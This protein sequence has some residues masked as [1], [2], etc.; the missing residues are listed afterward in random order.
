M[1][2]K[3]FLHNIE[4]ETFARELKCQGRKASVRTVVIPATNEEGTDVKIE[5]RVE[6]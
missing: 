3:T 5:Y 4:A 2:S 1:N 6:F